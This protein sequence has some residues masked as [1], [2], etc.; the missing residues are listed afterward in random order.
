MRVS[1]NSKVHE[2]YNN[3]SK[4]NDIALIELLVPVDFTRKY[5]YVLR[6]VYKLEHLESLVIVVW[7]F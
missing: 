4:D 1:I 6:T 7:C 3:E 2:E 5:L